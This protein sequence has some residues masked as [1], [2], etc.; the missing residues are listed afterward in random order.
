MEHALFGKR[1]LLQRASAKSRPVVLSSAIAPIP[2]ARRAL[3]H[4]LE[5]AEK[6]RLCLAMFESFV[7]DMNLQNNP[8]RMGNP[9]CWASHP[10]MIGRS[11]RGR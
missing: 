8:G 11:P 10:H 4:L 5:F 3:I 7:D 1:T 9:L 2:A 6:V